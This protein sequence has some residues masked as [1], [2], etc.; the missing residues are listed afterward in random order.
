MVRHTAGPILAIWSWPVLQ[1]ANHPLP[2]M[3]RQHSRLAC[4]TVAANLPVCDS[5]AAVSSMNEV[6]QPGRPIPKRHSSNSMTYR[7]RNE[8]RAG[9]SPAP[10]SLF[11]VL[12][13]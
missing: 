5:G 6:L 10:L 13:A 2:R 11:R 3:R 1:I 7:S 12:E 9:D 4:V 8:K